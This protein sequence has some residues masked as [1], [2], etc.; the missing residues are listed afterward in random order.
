MAV[1]APLFISPL[2]IP[3]PETAVARRRRLT[4]PVISMTSFQIYLARARALSEITFASRAT[5]DYVVR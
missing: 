5:R 3:P 4:E 2:L 1:N